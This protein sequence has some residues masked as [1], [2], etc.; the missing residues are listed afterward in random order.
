MKLCDVNVLIY[1]HREDASTEHEAYA[2]W[3]TEMATGPS[4]F[5]LSESVLSGF[6]RVVTNPRVFRHPTPL[7][8]ALRF[9]AALRDRPQAAILRPGERN[10]EIF[11]NLCRGLNAR[12]K[13]I[14]DAWHAALAIECGC[15]WISTDSDFARFPGLNWKH[16]LKV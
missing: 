3:L 5:G 9:C 13:L 1:A 14:A 15:E 10:W 6:V 12:G 4:A 7:E 8:K 11:Q 2:S 16:P